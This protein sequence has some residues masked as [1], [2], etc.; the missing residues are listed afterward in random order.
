VTFSL[1]YREKPQS[2][3]TKFR[4]PAVD[5][6]NLRG[7]RDLGFKV[8]PVDGPADVTGLRAA[9]D[10]GAVKLL[11]V[12]DTGP[13]GSLGDTEWIL[14]ARQAG[15]IS[16]LIVQ[17]VLKT[18][19]AEAADIVLPGCASVEKD[20]TF[21]NM[22]GHVQ[23]SS[24]VIMPPGDAVEDWQILSKVAL[25]LGGAVAEGSASAI[26]QAIAAELANVPGYAAL[27]DVV[28][29]R[30][31]AARQYLEASN[32]SARGKWEEMFL[33]P[34]K[35]GDDFGPLPRADVFPLRQVDS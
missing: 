27:A 10:T 18:E 19:L 31:V 22:T 23:A 13:D 35:F 21:T 7:V 9:V 12:I 1:R 32:E 29:S 26:R 4:I 11:Y 25:A 3:N 30:P 33:A 16:T 8:A 17:G 6:P 2:M 34:V 5:A 28:F 15:K 20:A 24:R 14:A